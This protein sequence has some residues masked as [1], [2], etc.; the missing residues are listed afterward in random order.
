MTENG[1]FRRDTIAV[2][3]KNNKNMKKK[4]AFDNLLGLGEG[5]P[6]HRRS[7]MRKKRSHTVCEKK[8]GSSEDEDDFDAGDDGEK[9][10]L[11]FYALVKAIIR[12]QRWN[13]PLYIGNTK[14]LENEECMSPLDFDLA[15]FKSDSWRSCP[16]KLKY[17]MT[18]A[19]WERSDEDV[20][21]IRN[22]E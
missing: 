1:T 6:R 14:D 22:I 4:T 5:K 7:I 2:Q 21:K 3:K 13:V 17:L 18:L 15:K 11:T 9:K 10:K 19:P 12:A 16:S 8:E 20:E